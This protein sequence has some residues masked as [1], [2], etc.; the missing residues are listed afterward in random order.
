[1]LIK[2][3]GNAFVRINQILFASVFAVI[4]L[5]GILFL[6]VVGYYLIC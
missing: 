6:G 2:S 3:W 1:M 4:N 5:T